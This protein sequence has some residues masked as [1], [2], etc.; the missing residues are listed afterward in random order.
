MVATKVQLACGS[1]SEGVAQAPSASL[2]QQRDRLQFVGPKRPTG[3]SSLL[4]MKDGK[5]ARIEVVA[6]RARLDALG[7]K[8]LLGPGSV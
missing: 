3:Q 2:S 7:G 8:V 4:V 6:N 5:I 1:A